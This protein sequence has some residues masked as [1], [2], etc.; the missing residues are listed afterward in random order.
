MASALPGRGAD[1]VRGLFLGTYEDGELV[2]R[3]GVGTGFT[4]RMRRETWEV[5]QLIRSDVPLRVKGMPW[6]GARACRC[7]QPRLLAEVEYTEITPDGLIRH[8]PFKGLR[9]DKDAR[10]VH[11]EEA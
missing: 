3:G 6:L 1:N 10:E 9:Q 5:L 8:P 2:Y 7:V 4:D 11:L